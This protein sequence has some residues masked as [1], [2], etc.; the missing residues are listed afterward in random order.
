MINLTQTWQL[1]YIKK[2][3]LI[4]INY[5]E[6]LDFYNQL[7]EFN[8]ECYGS[9][10]LEELYSWLWCLMILRKTLLTLIYHITEE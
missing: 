4:T 1:F 3:S 9:W 6:L 7:T 2:K 10:H 5:V 8:Y